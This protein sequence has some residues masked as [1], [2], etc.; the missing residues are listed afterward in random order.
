MSA[1]AV[2]PTFSQSSRLPLEIIRHIVSFIHNRPTL[3]AVCL[4]SSIFVFPA[5]VTLFSC[6]NVPE[7]SSEKI[8]SL[9]SS[10]HILQH[11][12]SVIADHED[13]QLPALLDNISAVEHASVR[14]TSLTFVSHLEHNPWTTTLLRPLHEKILPFLSSLT[15]DAVIAPL[16]LVTSC[17]S[18]Q[19]LRAYGSL[20]YTES[21]PEFRQ[22]FKED[23][24]P[25][26][27]L[28]IIPSALEFKLMPFLTMLALD[29]TQNSPNSPVGRQICPL[30]ELIQRGQ[31]PSLKCLDLSRNDAEW[32]PLQNIGKVVKPL[33]N[34]LVCLDIGYWPQWDTDQANEDH[35]QDLDLFQIQ[36]YP[37]LVFFSARLQQYRGLDLNEEYDQLMCHLEC[38]LSCF[39]NLA[40]PHPLK[41]LRLQLAGEWYE[42][43]NA[44]VGDKYEGETWPQLS[45]GIWEVLDSALAVNFNLEALE[46]IVIPIL[47]EFH[48]MRQAVRDNLPMLGAA[49]ELSFELTDIG[50]YFSSLV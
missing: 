18:L 6:L 10:P 3:K 9:T 16:F 21:D 17:T 46:K 38:L 50:G 15:L 33:M 20:L 28:K 34:Q 30:V 14:L 5:Q 13:T 2:S 12:R 27:H 45:A 37:N 39:R 41:I 31:F 8:Q 32:F 1:T 36:H 44:D 42:D 22:L 40:F 23:E 35:M 24:F 48:I 29:G 7:T 25:L 4:T 11:I 43:K 26:K 49:R 47:P 19:C